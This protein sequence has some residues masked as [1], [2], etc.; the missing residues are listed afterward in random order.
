[1]LKVSS[2]L[3]VDLLPTLKVKI[4][5]HQLVILTLRATTQKHL[6]KRHTLKAQVQKQLVEHPTPK[7][8]LQ[9]LPEFMGMLKVDKHLPQVNTLMLK[10]IALLQVVIILTL[11]VTIQKH[12]EKIHTLKV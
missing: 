2:Q 6:E 3:L 4:L 9:Q 8:S 5:S 12:L 1:M 11:K 10:V 7:A